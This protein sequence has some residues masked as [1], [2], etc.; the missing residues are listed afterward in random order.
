MSQL[1]RNYRQKLIA[2][3]ESFT[4]ENFDSASFSIRT[5][6]SLT[7]ENGVDPAVILTVADPSVTIGLGRATSYMK[8]TASGGSAIVFYYL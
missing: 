8:L 1:A 7:V 3:G 2:D 6:C 5:G 4:L